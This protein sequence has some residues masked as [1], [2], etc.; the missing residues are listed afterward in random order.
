MINR[1]YKPNQIKNK[2]EL[3]TQLLIKMMQY[4]SNENDLI[5]DFF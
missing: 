2:N 1:E 3:P 4:S 5:C